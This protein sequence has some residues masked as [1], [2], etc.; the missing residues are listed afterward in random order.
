MAHPLDDHPLRTLFRAPRSAVR[1]AS[2]WDRSGG[3][4]DFIR[5]APGETATLLEE[6]GA[7]CINRIYIAL[8]AP[9]LTDYRDAVLRCFWD[10]E[11][12]PSV[13][14]PLGDFFGVTH[15][16]IRSTTARS[17]R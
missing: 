17:R 8:A 14:V 7:G 4:N 10:G 2:S 15:G 13:E 16:R 5:I 3:N 11:S 6:V 1:R 9:E 12:T